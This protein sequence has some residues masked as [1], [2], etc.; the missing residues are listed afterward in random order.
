MVLALGQH[1]GE[2]RA[3][4]VWS[5]NYLRKAFITLHNTNMTLHQ[6]IISFSN[7]TFDILQYYICNTIR[8]IEIQPV[9]L[10]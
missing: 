4:W 3:K 10:F 8:M 2:N 7:L 6:L 5:D 1:V 9:C